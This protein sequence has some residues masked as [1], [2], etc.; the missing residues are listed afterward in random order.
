MVK[1]ENTLIWHYI[2]RGNGTGLYNR[3]MGI[4]P[5]TKYAGLSYAFGRVDLFPERFLS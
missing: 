2:Q 5:G 1:E 3:C 4:G